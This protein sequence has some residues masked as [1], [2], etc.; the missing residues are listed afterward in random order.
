MRYYALL[1][2]FLVT[3]V[4][5]G[6]EGSWQASGSGVQLN[7]RGILAI[8]RPLVSAEPVRGVMGLVVWRYVVSGETPAGL[9]VNL[10][11]TRCIPLEGKTGTTR[12]FVG[13]PASEALYFVWLVPG[14]GTFSP[15]MTILSNQV[16]VNYHLE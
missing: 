4:L 15:T 9:Q 2:L 7:H 5:A 1:L 14:S 6:G 11:A 3:Q 8:S 12:A 10:C 13:M 16:I